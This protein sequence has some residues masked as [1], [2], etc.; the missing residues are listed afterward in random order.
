MGYRHSSL[1]IR[2]RNPYFEKFK[3]SKLEILKIL[4][5]ETLVLYRACNP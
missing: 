3:L 2:I 1:L 4:L 5:I